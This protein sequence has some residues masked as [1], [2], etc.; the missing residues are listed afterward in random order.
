MIKIVRND[1]FTDWVQLFAFGDFVEEYKNIDKAIKTAKKLAQENK[2]H[3]FVFMDQ[4]VSVD[5]Y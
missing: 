2:T 4:I 3:F 5:S 1:N